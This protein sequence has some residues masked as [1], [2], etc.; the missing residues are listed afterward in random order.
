MDVVLDTCALLSLAGT[1]EKELSKK[2]LQ[3]IE[4][5]DRVFIST[6]TCFELCLKHKRGNLR[7]PRA[8]KPETFWQQCVEYYS[9][10]EVPVHAEDFAMAV[11]LPEHHMDPFDRII[12]AQAARL[13]STIVTY[14][15]W[16][17]AYTGKCIS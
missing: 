12:I 15:K 5:A 2:C 9:L 1:V 7:F 16:F 13:K 3:V 14:D 17:K 6:C 4:E 11:Q 10:T 8:L